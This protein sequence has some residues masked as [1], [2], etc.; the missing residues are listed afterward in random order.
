MP[1]KSGCPARDGRAMIGD[2][3]ADLCN[4]LICFEQT[5]QLPPQCNDS[6]L[7]VL[8]ASHAEHQSAQSSEGPTRVGLSVNCPCYISSAKLSETTDAESTLL[9]CFCEMKV[10]TGCWHDST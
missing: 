8:S 9:K 1:N 3:L 10:A 2:S 6:D 7:F 4:A 5:P